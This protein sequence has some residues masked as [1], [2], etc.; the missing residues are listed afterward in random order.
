MF[1]LPPYEKTGKFSVPCSKNET[2]TFFPNND[3]Y[4]CVH[5]CIFFQKM[6]EYSLVLQNW[7]N[8]VQRNVGDFIYFP[9]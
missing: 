2:W 9:I 7:L 4:Y 3:S 8:L 5:F 6:V 1:V